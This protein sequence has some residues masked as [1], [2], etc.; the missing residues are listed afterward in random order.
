[1]TRSMQP[2]EIKAID[3]THFDLWLPLWNGYQR[4]YEV[5]IPASVTLKTWARFLDPAEPMYAALAV[6]GEQ[7]LGLVHAVYHRS[8]WTAADHCYLQDLFVAHAA[9]GGGIGRGLIEHVY[10]DARRRGASRVHWLTHESNHDA[11]QLY[12]RIA[13]RSG[14]TQYRKQFA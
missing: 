6:M 9:R 12:D 2:V 7:A 10:A 8:T 1:M 14:F 3:H 11:M 5:D 13:Q 4:F